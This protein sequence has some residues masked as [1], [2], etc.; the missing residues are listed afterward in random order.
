M[1]GPALALLREATDELEEEGYDPPRIWCE[2]ASAETAPEQARAVRANG[3]RVALCDFGPD[4]AG[5][6]AATS[7]SPDYVRF[8]GA[9]FRTVARAPDAIG[10]L[11]RL[12][13]L[14][15]A[16][17]IEVMVDGVETTPQF[18]AA[19]EI[20]AD[21]FQGFLFAPPFLAGSAFTQ[22][23]LRLPELLRPH[24]KIIPLRRPA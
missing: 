12:T 11:T 1:L 2:F 3:F 8:D 6:S 24:A 18:E 22:R 4:P 7:A 5:V 9:W 10:L 16:E 19:L 23:P 20:G 14:L 15:H 17:G 21:M 13:A